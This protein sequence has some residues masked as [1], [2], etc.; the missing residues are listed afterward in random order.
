M[1]PWSSDEVQIVE[2][3]MSN[4][5]ANGTIHWTHAF[6]EHPEWKDTLTSNGRSLGAIFAKGNELRNKGNRLAKYT[7]ADPKKKGKGKGKGKG[8]KKN[9]LEQQIEV[10]AALVDPDVPPVTAEKPKWEVNACPNCT[11]NVKIMNDAYAKHG[12]AAPPHCPV[13][14]FPLKIARNVIN[15]ALRHP[16]GV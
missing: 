3:I 4:Y 9:R 13:C 11:L 15:I 7:A 5:G 6:N 1:N 14:T 16:Q 2:Q 12:I 10:D 8:G